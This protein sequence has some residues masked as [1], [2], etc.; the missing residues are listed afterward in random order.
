MCLVRISEQEVIAAIYNIKGSDFLNETER[1]YCAVRNVSLNIIQDKFRQ[2]RSSHL[3][4]LG[5]I[6]TLCAICG[7]ERGKGTGFPPITS[8]FSCH[9]QPQILHT[10][11]HLHVA[12]IRRTKG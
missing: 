3:G 10:H 9:Y 8:V 4:G 7:G 11:L 5:S 12:L 2:S 6:E 1:V